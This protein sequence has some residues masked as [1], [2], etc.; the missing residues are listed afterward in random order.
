MP[1]IAAEELP[2]MELFPGALSGIVAG[3]R[4]MLSFLEMTE[5]SEVPEHSHQLV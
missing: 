5:G 2:K 3:E 1:F 4:L